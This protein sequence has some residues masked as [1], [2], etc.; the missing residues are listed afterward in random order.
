MLAHC[1]FSVFCIAACV[2]RVVVASRLPTSFR[3]LQLCCLLLSTVVTT[4]LASSSSSPVRSLTVTL[5]GKQYDVRGV[6]TVRDLQEQLENKSGVAP[7]Q[8]GRVIF[9]GKRLDPDTILTE[10][11]VPRE[12]AQLNMVP[13]SGGS[14]KKKS[15]SSGGGGGTKAAA[16]ATASSAG[17]ASAS[18]PMKD[19][20]Q[21]SGVDTSQLDEMMKGVGG[22]GG[23]GSGPSMQDS[24]K[25]M[26]DAMN[27]PLFKEMMNDPERLEQSRQMILNNPM[28]KSMMAGM[29]GMEDIL[30][31]KDAWREAMQA[32]AELYQNMD[33]DQL[34]KAMSGMDGMMG[35]MGGGMG[36]NNA[37]TNLFDGTLDDSTATAALDE[38][39]ED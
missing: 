16:T 31:D 17:P 25:A 27:S 22:G 9:G 20:L 26:T 39:D 19:Y 1:L 14:K 38:L 35:S 15:S 29:P 3:Y 33:P 32:A 24:I 36:A 2:R 13:S 8:Q 11:G 6:T 18:N 7:K 12:G 23:D 5:R 37:G 10:V 30:N 28:L 4:V 21:Q 34:M